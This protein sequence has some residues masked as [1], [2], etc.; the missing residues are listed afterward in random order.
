MATSH[1][2]LG[3]CLLASTVFPLVDVAGATALARSGEGPA[4][5]QASAPGVSFFLGADVRPGPPSSAAVA[6]GKWKMNWG[7]AK[8]AN[9][10]GAFM[11][12][13]MRLCCMVDSPF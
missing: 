8:A 6:I 11:W 10:C 3:C 12:T 5:A 13:S 7:S 9:H 2:H 1:G 4:A